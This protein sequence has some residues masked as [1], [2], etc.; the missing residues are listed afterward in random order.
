MAAALGFQA[1]VHMSCDAKAWKKDRLRARGVEVIEHKGD[2]GTAVAAGRAQ[3]RAG[4]NT[5]FVDDENSRHWFL[6]YRVAALHLKQ[7]LAA[8]QIP[9]DATHPLFVYLPCGVGGA[10]GG[11][12]F[13][14]R[15]IFGDYAHCFIAE[16]LTAPCM[17]IRLAAFEDRAISIRD[18][19]LEIHAEAD[20]LAVGQASEFAAPLMRPLASGAFTVPDDDLFEDVY[21]LE[22]T[23]SIHIEPSAAAGFRGPHWLLSSKMGRTY[24]AER[25]T[26]ADLTRATHVLW[27]TGGAFVPEVEYRRFHERGANHSPG[28]PNSQPNTHIISTAY[29]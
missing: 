3:A 14:L 8:Q 22:R 2:F 1:T 24:L 12:T 16:P 11:I 25:A 9:V 18:V 15:A 29:H 28:P 17:L 27:T 13:G 20:G 26:S 10:P 21:R 7:Q 4:T 6:G 5:Y 23:E 19:G